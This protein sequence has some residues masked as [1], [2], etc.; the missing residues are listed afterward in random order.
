MKKLLATFS[1]ALLALV[2]WLAWPSDE[3]P[4]NDLVV[5]EVVLEE[6]REL[7]TVAPSPTSRGL[8]E[9]AP[10]ASTALADVSAAVTKPA[11]LAKV[12]GRL[13]L[14]N[15][16]PASGVK[17]ALT[18]HQSWKQD[19]VR[20]GRPDDLQVP[21]SVL[22]GPEGR[23]EFSFEPPPDVR[24]ELEASLAKHAWESWRWRAMQPGELRD[25]G[26]LKL[27]RTGEVL[28][29]LVDRKGDPLTGM[30]IA[31]ATPIRPEV[32]LGGVHRTTRS[33]SAWEREPD[34]RYLI[35]HVPVGKVRLHAQSPIIDRV[36]G[37]K[38]QVRAGRTSQATIRYRGPETSAKLRLECRTEK[39]RG[40]H[41]QALASVRLLKD[42]KL[43]ALGSAKPRSWSYIFEGLEPGLY[44]IE[45]DDPRF[46]RWSR[47][48]IK[49]GGTVRATL[50]GNAAIVLRVVDDATD[51][52]LESY[53]LRARF[54]PGEVR[55][56][57]DEVELLEAGA[58]PPSGGRFEGMLPAAQVLVIESAGYAHFESPQLDLLPGETRQ[59]EAR[60]QRG[61]DVSGRFSSALGGLGLD[62]ASVFLLPTGSA[63]RSIPPSRREVL[64]SGRTYDS[65]S[66]QREVETDADGRFAFES[67]PP[68]EYALLGHA[69]DWLVAT[70]DPVIVRV[71]A[72]VHG[73]ELQAVE[74]ARLTGQLIG[75]ERASFSEFLVE[76]RPS[77]ESVWPRHLR[78]GPLIVPVDEAGYFDLPA[79][80]VGKL[81]LL[82]TQA[83]IQVAEGMGMFVEH[84]GLAMYLAEL[85]LAVGE[86]RELR[87]DLSQRWPGSAQVTVREG[88]QPTEAL[89]VMLKPLDED[90][91]AGAGTTD[92]DGVARMRRVEPGEYEVHVL[93]PTEG[94]S[95]NS[96]LLVRVE[97]GT[98]TKA[99]VSYQ[100]ASGWLT[101]LDAVDGSPLTKQHVRILAPRGTP[102]FGQPRTGPDG[103]LK[104]TLPIGRYFVSLSWSREAQNQ[105][106]EFQ[107]TS[108]GSTPSELRL[109]R[110]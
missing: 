27:L 32:G 7:E 73:L 90:I 50:K 71:G 75:P 88:A 68:G 13:L 5:P 79:L 53:S 86:E 8:R 52:E 47:S 34:G 31:Y 97:S 22:S 99:E 66:F 15:G 110:P 82:L 69:N 61:V 93:S 83:P 100:L 59:V 102:A 98:Q 46:E 101:I 16:A 104:L 44:T 78:E 23:F 56:W 67:I 81:T 108:G 94:W 64:M 38:L 85:E 58:K 40:S 4:R 49:L 55:F 96:E 95:W 91:I 19:G 10:Q 57:P 24:Y 62:A 70:L 26:D 14:P 37:P 43:V 45:I 80:P 17:L 29:S 39:S 105:G 21:E 18:G 54:L 20:R 51:E 107:W 35:K 30:W 87:F 3:R 109:E 106:L 76:A 60:M 42:G 12:I 25:L 84:R 41:L 1:L 72:P 11:S 63:Q 65:L 103:R 2:A 92:A 6:Q 74:T 77:A 9:E 33:F 48:G 36:P 28:V 89:V